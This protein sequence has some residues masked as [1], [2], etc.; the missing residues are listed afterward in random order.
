MDEQA[1]A[2]APAATE[3]EPVACVLCEA[4]ID[5]LEDAWPEDKLNELPAFLPRSAQEVVK[6]HNDQQGFMPFCP[7][8]SQFFLQAMAQFHRERQAREGQEETAL[9]A[10]V[11]AGIA[12]PVKT[13]LKPGDPGFRTP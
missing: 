6:I 9:R 7:P 2:S 1:G 3:E 4:L 5:W 10:R 12:T 11:G 13:I 8:C